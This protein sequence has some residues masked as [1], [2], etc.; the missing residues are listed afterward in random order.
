MTGTIPLADH[1]DQGSSLG[2]IL[3]FSEVERGPGR[4]VL[5]AQA[6]DDLRNRRGVIH[7]GVISALL[8]CALGGAVVA[9]IDPEEW[10]ATLQLSVQY[11][12]GA[13]RGPLRATG[14]MTG[15]GRTCAFAE[16]EVVDADGRVTSRA[17]GTWHI[18]PRRPS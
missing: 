11:I 5:E 8:D 9:G 17:Q 14:R 15:R 4:L 7:G 10:C 13:S 3:G 6:R 2:Q 16:G 1:E 12:R 18:W